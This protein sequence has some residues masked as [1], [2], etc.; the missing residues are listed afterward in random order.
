MVGLS[1]GPTQNDDPLDGRFEPAI[2]F[3]HLF[4]RRSFSAHT[5]DT[6][7]KAVFPIHAGAFL[8]AIIAGFV[9]TCLL[10]DE[11]SASIGLAATF[12][13]A[14]RT[15]TVTK[16]DTLPLVENNFTKRFKFD[17]YDNPKLKQ[18]REQY[19]L[20]EIVSPGKNEFD[21]QVLLLDWVN[22]QFKKF[23]RP[24]ANPR[25]AAEILRD[26]GQGHTF[27]CAQY[28]DVFVS[29]AAS[30]GWIDRSL[31]LRR[32]NNIGAGSSEHSST[33]IWSN[34]F[35]K[36]VMLD[37]TFA[38]YAEKNGLPLSAYEL[39][40]EWFYHDAKDVTFVVDKD[41]KRYRKS[42]MPIFRARYAG[43]GDLSLDPGAVNPYAFIGYVP[44]TN[45]MDAGPDYG[46]MFI[47]QDKLC[48]GTEWHKRDIPPDLSSDA[49]FPIGQAA[50]TLSADGDHLRAGLKTMTPNF[51]TF[52]VRSDAGDWKPSGDRFAWSVHPGKNRLEAKTVNRFGIEGPVSIA[53]VKID[54][55]A[56]VTTP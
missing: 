31:A 46:K 5:G 47:F 55:D 37:P 49:Y 52:L 1:S 8:A 11:P 27:F 44:N 9:S 34:Q 3:Q 23:G 36:W 51:K 39:R 41:R 22:H 45:L 10:A 16:L 26:I 4:Q 14:G 48:N 15:A 6:A 53:E 19:K 18:L 29:A 30:F 42:N 24:T 17:S 35:R 32:P 40:Q 7:M 20:D 56:A 13:L 28:A 50:M 33:E 38:M 25:G 12:H 43:F 21:R 2:Q 54:A